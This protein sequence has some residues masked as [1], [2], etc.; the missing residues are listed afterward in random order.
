MIRSAIAACEVYLLHLLALGQL[1]LPRCAVMPALP[2]G[3]QNRALG[4]V[5]GLKFS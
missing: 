1:T 2:F 3:R 5:L 4:D